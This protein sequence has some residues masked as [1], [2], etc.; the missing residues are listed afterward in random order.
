M[1]NDGKLKNK[2]VETYTDDMVKAIESDKGG[3][4]KKII[5]EEE[6][7]EAEKIN[8]SPKSRKNRLFMFISIVLIFLALAVLIFLAFF[9]EN[10][11]I[12]SITPQTTSIIF[13]DQTDFKAI[14]GFNKDQIIG[15]ILN[16][17]NNT[18]IKTGGVGGI[19]LT[20]NKKVVSFKKFNALIKSNLILDQSNLISDNFLLGAVNKEVKS[21]LS[22]GDNFF[23]LLKVRS[24]TDIF[25]VMLSWENKMLYDLSG[26]FGI[27]INPLTNYLFT[28][29]WQNGIVENK[30]ARILKNKDGKIILMY[31]YVNDSFV[32]ITNSE[33]A[34]REII[35]RLASSQI[36]K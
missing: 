9:N 6:E 12:V 7:H 1:E 30:N 8:L 4:I 11:N 31:V 19:Y 24:F 2:N 34:T 13:T 35:L 23:I 29:D 17:I 32:I 16:Q 25:P 15:T 33:I 21:T 26:F 5:H 18:K 14:D 36:K 10:I 22:V 28:K 3:L 27:N 20:E